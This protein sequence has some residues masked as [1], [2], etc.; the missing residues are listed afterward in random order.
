[1]QEFRQLLITQIHGLMRYA[2]ALLGNYSSAEDLVQDCMEHALGKYDQ[3]DRSR[4]IKP[5]LF[6][7]LHNI[8]IDNQRKNATSPIVNADEDEILAAVAPSQP[9]LLALRDVSRHLASLPPEQREVLL[10]VSLGGLE[11]KE[12]GKIIGVPVGTVMSRLHRARK[13]LSAIMQAKNGTTAT[14]QTR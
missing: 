5:W 1:M 9:D 10:M 4:S 14:E 12:I 3:W 7:I 6:R 8:F 2:L 13:Q 11:Y